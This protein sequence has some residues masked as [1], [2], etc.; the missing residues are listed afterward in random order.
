MTKF[1]STNIFKGRIK[2]KLYATIKWLSNGFRRRPPSSGAHS[3]V[4][5][6]LPTVSCIMPQRDG[7]ERSGRVMDDKLRGLY[8]QLGLSRDPAPLPSNDAQDEKG[9]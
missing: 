2:N 5:E 7:Y 3:K 4:K 8:E 9:R 6:P 1:S